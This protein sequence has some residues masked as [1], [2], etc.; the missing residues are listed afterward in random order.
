MT[1]PDAIPVKI[2]CNTC[3]ASL[4]E[5]WMK[6]RTH[7][8]DEI[9]ELRGKIEHLEHFGDAALKKLEERA[10]D[11]HD[12]IADLQKVE[13]ALGADIVAL[14]E[15]LVAKD[16]Q[17]AELQQAAAEQAAQSDSA[18]IEELP[19]PIENDDWPCELSDPARA[20]EEDSGE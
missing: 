9:V 5:E 14:A 10:S 16:K 17:I 6:C 3:G 2:T 13:E 15:Q 1:T 18:R 19:S 12:T 8:I 11:D 7:Y 4:P 20:D